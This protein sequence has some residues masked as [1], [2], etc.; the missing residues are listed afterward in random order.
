[1]RRKRWLYM[2]N[3]EPI[4]LPKQEEI[5]VTDLDALPQPQLAG[6]QWR[7]LGS[8]LQCDSCPFRHTQFIPPEYQLYGI[9]EKGIPMIR[10][11][12]IH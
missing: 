10:K 9:D 6:H 8:M 1:M 12:E 7:Q 5:Y 2:T 11:I 3:E 4:Q